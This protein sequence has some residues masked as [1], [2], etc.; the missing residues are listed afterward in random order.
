VGTEKNLI[1]IWRLEKGRLPVKVF[2]FTGSGPYAACSGFD[3]VP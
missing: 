1:I 3:K 2:I